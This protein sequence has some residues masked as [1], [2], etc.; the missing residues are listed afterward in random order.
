MKKPILPITGILP[1]IVALLLLASAGS[2]YAQPGS[3]FRGK[4]TDSL[5][6]P[7]A[8][9][10]V[11]VKGSKSGV[12]TDSAGIFTINASPSATLI[13]SHIGYADLSVPARSNL[14]AI[15]LVSTAREMSDVVVV[16]YGTQRKATLTGAVSVVSAKAFQDKGPVSN[17]LESLQGQVPG[18]IVTRTSGQP[19]RENWQFQMRGATSTNGANPL[20]ILDGV[21]IQSDNGE[22]NSLNPADIDNISFLKDASAAIYGAR[23]AFGVVLITTKRAKAGRPVI[24]YDATVSRKYTALMPHLLNVRQW[25]QGLMQ[26]QINDNYG[27]TPPSTNTWYEAGVFAAN[28]PD[29]GYIDLT[30]LPGYSGSAAT[31]L[32]YNGLQVPLFGDVKDLTY[33]NTDMQR[34]LWG[35]A[36]STM[37]NLS[38]SARNDRSGYRV[39]LGYLND[40]SQLQWGLNGSQRYNIRLNHDYTF[41]KGLRL[42]TNIALEKNT[43]QQ[44][45][46]LTNGGY[47]ALSNY[48]QPG[49]PAFSKNGQPYEWGTVYSAPGQLSLGGNNRTDNSRILLTS[50]LNYNIARHLTFTGTAGYNAYFHDS[51]VQQKQIQYYSYSGK[52]ALNTF[53]T[54]G[55]LGGNGTYYSRNNGKD[56]YYNLI[57]RLEYHNTFNNDHEVSIMGGTSYERDEYDFYGTTTYDLA[58]DN[59]SSLNLGVNSG[60]A[61]YVTNYEAQNHYALSSFF[62]RAMYNYKS[63]YL[64][65][66][67]GRYDGSSKFIQQNRWKAFYGISGGWRISEES[68]MKHQNVVSDLKLR[69]SYGETGNQG[70]IGLYDYLQLLNANANQALLGATPVVS[71]TTTA[72]LVSLNRTW[73]TVKNT[74]IGIDFAILKNRLSGTFDYFW[75]ENTNMLLGQTYPGVLGATAPAANIGLLK[76]WGWE[77]MLT[78]R[79]NVGKDISYNVSVT[80]TDNRNKLVHYGGANVLG[81]GY[82]STVE[83]YP[84]NS[85]FGLVYAGRI[86][87]QKQ[88]DA[89]NSAYAPAGSTNNINLPVPTPLAS[90][91]GQLSGLRPGDN[92]FRDVNGDGKLS[93]GTST[94]NPGD[95]VYLGRDDPRYSY[96]INLGVQW[97]GFDLLTI[98][99][100]IGQR[101]IFRSS[102]WRV[103]YGTVFQG[104]SNA[105]WGQIW[106]PENPHAHFPNLHSNGNSI[107]NTYN[108]QISSWSI[109]NGA[110]LRLKNAVVGYTL[111]NRLMQH[112]KAVQRIRFY[113]SGSDLWE[114]SHIHDGW[115]PEST[116]TVATNERYPFYRYLTFGANVTF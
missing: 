16:G 49:I 8:G 25:G 63:K 74:N 10:N 71:V 116:R 37:H 31:G 114:K 101:T 115:D 107:I 77:G 41:A 38:F 39:S 17:P 28:P 56:P 52:I 81:A 60:T 94:K 69:A 36:T 44:P 90:P 97:K 113:V 64:L 46:M 53:P 9:A 67:L 42:E 1:L 76:T 3:P 55:T 98:F 6:Q 23:A 51:S 102:N 100:G 104:Q 88:L 18:V 84:L 72:N 108:Y 12:A 22:L 111:P 70:G 75:K 99:Q 65:E 68:F 35:N 24:Q 43:I 48:S 54:A 110:Y 14:G 15:H 5:G 59:T 80:F 112:L 34:M 21:A 62:G 58:N 93:I 2:L 4:V 40:G 61:G 89:Y 79:D 26:A 7:L 33:I 82:N 66:V 85:Y 13:I 87:T 30:A 50:T 109:E 95:L 32:L 20:V 29:S 103:P 106:S 73:E 57:A 86:Q 96:G 105:W 47:S 92:M 11:R 19:G 78:W 91:A 83:G 27:V 45:S